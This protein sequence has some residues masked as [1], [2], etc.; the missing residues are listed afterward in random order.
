MYATSKFLVS[1]KVKKVLVPRHMDLKLNYQLPL[2]SVRRVV[3][4]RGD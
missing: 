1:E 4:H 3:V 2:M